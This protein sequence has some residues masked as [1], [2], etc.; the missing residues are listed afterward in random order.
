LA[1]YAESVALPLLREEMGADR[2]VVFPTFQAALAAAKAGQ[3]VGIAGDDIEIGR[4]L[5][6]HADTGIR[7]ETHLHRDRPLTVAMALPWNAEN[8]HA[9]LN[10][11]LEKCTRGGML[12]K[13]WTKHLG[14]ARMRAEK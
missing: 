11:Y 14:E 9:W 3:A 7:W 2:I 12:S 13:L 5:S 6:E 1:V 4:W 8:L 10:L